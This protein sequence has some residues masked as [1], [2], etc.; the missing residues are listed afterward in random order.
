[1]R[2][3]DVAWLDLPTG[4][5]AYRRGGTGRPLLLIHGWG[6]SS[7]YWM[8]AFV[9]LAGCRDVIAI[10]LPGFGSSPPP[11]GSA[12]LADLTAITI[13][14]ADA[15]GLETLSL[16][17]HSLGAGVALMFAAAQPERVRRLAL[18]SFGLPRTPN[19]EALFAGL[20]V[21]L[22]ANAALWAPWL[23][24][25]SPWVAAVR[26][27]NQL[28]WTTPPLPVLLTAQA[29]YSAAEVPFAALALGVADMA[30]MD[31]RVAVEAAS[32]AGDPAVAVAARDL[33]VPALV[34]SGREDQIFPPSTATALARVLPNG[35]LVLFDR[36]GHVP[37]AECPA[38]F[39]TAMGA[40]LTL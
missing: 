31:L 39:Y 32:S 3:P 33:T 18:V 27:W 9:T 13:A 34:L 30:T 11:R 40:F 37:M 1:M 19:E 5:L 7:R 2:L 22:S 35:G 36:C 26:P 23:T 8:G 20:H 29:V 25:W 4:P 14:A 15:L 16:A 28:L 38:P 12:S 6:G 21:Q 17:G 10:D 24:M